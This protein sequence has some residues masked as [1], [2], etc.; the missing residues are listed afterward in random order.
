MTKIQEPTLEEQVEDAN[1][2]REEIFTELNNLRTNN[3]KLSQRLINAQS[4][5]AI[6]HNI[7][8]S[9]F[10]ATTEQIEEL[11]TTNKNT[12][13]EFYIKV[14]GVTN[15]EEIPTN[16]WD[17]LYRADFGF[18][19][20]DV[21]DKLIKLDSLEWVSVYNA[22][23]QSQIRH[24]QGIKEELSTDSLNATNFEEAIKDFKVL[25]ED[26]NFKYKQEPRT[27][28]ETK[29]KYNALSEFIYDNERKH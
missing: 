1:N 12:L 21:L 9:D 19:E 13:K 7:E 15:A 17:S 22:T 2:R 18:K 4:R 20:S 8:D 5:W 28:S 24:N 14:E 29:D 6:E 23:L 26:A 27:L 11:V 25:A 10:E 16:M 3:K